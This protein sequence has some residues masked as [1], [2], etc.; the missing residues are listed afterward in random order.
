MNASVTTSVVKPT[1][2]VVTC[3]I[4]AR[5]HLHFCNNSTALPTFMVQFETKQHINIQ[6]HNDKTSTIVTLQPQP[7]LTENNIFSI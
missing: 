2:S 3:L 1:S 7:S 5:H 6:Q 4:P